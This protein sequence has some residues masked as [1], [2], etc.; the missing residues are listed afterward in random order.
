MTSTE[1][2]PIDGQVEFITFRELVEQITGVPFEDIYK[3]FILQGEN[4]GRATL[5]NEQVK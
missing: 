2:T 5:T 1:H 3:N 4:S